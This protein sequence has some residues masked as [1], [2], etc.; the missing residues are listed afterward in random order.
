MDENKGLLPS[1]KAV[2]SVVGALIMFSLTVICISVMIFYSVPVVF[3]MQ[4]E[5]KAQKIEQAFTILDS[6]ISKVALGESPLQTTTV[7]LMGGQINV[8]GPDEIDKGMMTIQIINQT[9]NTKEEFNCS[10]G[11]IEYV[12]D[13]RKIAYEGGGVW[14]DYGQ[15]GGAIMISPPEFHYNGVTLTL[16]IMKI[17]GNSSSSGKGDINIA[18]TS[19]NTPYV[20]YPNTS[21]HRTN[22]VTHDKIIVYIKSDY[23]KAWANY[24]D[25]MVYTSATT[26]EINKT[27]IIQF[28]T[29]PPMGE[30]SLINKLRIAQVNASNTLPFYDFAFHLE[31][32]D[33]NSDGLNPDN[34]EMKATSG[35]K[36]L[37]YNFQKKKGANQL[38]LT[39]TYEDTIIGTK[40]EWTG[41]NLYPVSGKKADQYATVDLLNS[42]FMMEYEGDTEFSWNQSGPTTELPDVYIEPGNKSFSVNDLTQ[43]Y[44]KLIA[45][46]DTVI[47]YIDGGKSD[48]VDYSTSKIT[49]NYDSIG[50][51][52]TYLHITQNE[53]DVSVLN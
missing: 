45:K 36:T 20:L 25:T 1:C 50:N 10:L 47:F 42:S 12:K 21:A 40:E 23:Y 26:N 3:E 2:S 22:P 48:P 15:K 49:L 53:L 35:T 31:A 51:V 24:A 33:T 16:P 9:S 4:E 8:N 41:I 34:Y 6:R 14:S 5:A 44:I 27:A 19:D 38:Y 29:T 43:H 30:F 13:G 7:S 39:V 52:I 32:E 28:H 46:D 18:V 11:T 17:N 37:T